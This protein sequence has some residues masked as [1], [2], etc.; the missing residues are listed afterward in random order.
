MMRFTVVSTK[1]CVRKATRP[2]RH[3]PTPSALES[4]LILVRELSIGLAEAALASPDLPAR[5]HR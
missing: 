5:S 4:L 3:G 1:G 2:T